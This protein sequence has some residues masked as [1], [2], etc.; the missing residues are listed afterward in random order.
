MKKEDYR[1]NLE[2]FTREEIDVFVCSKYPFIR[3]CFMK[4]GLT[5][6]DREDLAQDTVSLVYKHIRTLRDAGKIDAW[7]REIA[8]NKLLKFLKSENKRKAAFDASRPIEEIAISDNE[9]SDLC[10]LIEKAENNERLKSLI[11]T[12]GEPDIT[13]FKLYYVE[14]YKLVEISKLKEINLNTVKSI[15]ARGLKKLKT[16]L[17]PLYGALLSAASWH[18]LYLPAEIRIKAKVQPVPNRHG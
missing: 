14:E 18:R 1:K 13:I 16:L 8:K 12:L 9:M 3:N 11:E 7:I 2:D 10:D 4:Q 15:H 5:P 17:K 6:E